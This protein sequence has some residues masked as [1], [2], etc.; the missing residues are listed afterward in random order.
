MKLKQLFFALVAMLSCFV[1][2]ANAQNENV[3]KIGDTEYAN[4]SAAISAATAGQTIT[5]IGDVN[6]SVTVDKNLTIDGANFNYTGTLTAKKN[7]TVTVQNVNF[8]NAGFTKEKSTNGKYTIKNCT[9]D[10]AKK[11]YDYALRIPGAN[12]VTVVDCTV[13]DYSYGFMYVSSSLTTHSVKN[14]TVENCNYG[15]R[16]A[17]TNT[18]NL[19]NFVTSNVKYPVQIQANAARTV[20]MTDC[21]IYAKDNTEQ[22][23]Y[24]EYTNSA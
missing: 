19:V 4:L 3:A 12:T 13:K 22:C 21:S 17:S 5:F 7:L 15:V 1:L 8:V 11:T 16:M 10:G 2:S 24:K 20:N 14:V 23:D 18:T 6:E 9:F